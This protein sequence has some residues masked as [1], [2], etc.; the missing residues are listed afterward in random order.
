MMQLA[1]GTPAGQML[2]ASCFPAGIGQRNPGA[3]LLVR[4]EA[5]IAA[6]LV[7][8]SE[9]R[10]VWLLDEKCA[11]PDQDVGPDHVLDRVQDL[12]MPDERVEPGRMSI[13][14]RTPFDVGG[15]DG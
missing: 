6:V 3:N 11:R 9:G 15:G 12:R 13:S 7:P 10:R 2:H 14:V 4:F 5:E 1:S 8:G